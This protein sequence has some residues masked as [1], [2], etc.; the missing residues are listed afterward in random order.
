MFAFEKFSKE[1]KFYTKD[2]KFKEKFKVPLRVEG[3]ILGAD[4]SDS[5]LTFGC[6]ASD[7]QIHFYLST[8]KGV[9]YLKSI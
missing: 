3:F 4:F 2:L 6:T 5:Q 1:V 9:R 8:S 7:S